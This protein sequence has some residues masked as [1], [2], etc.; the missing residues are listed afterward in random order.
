[1][2][3]NKYPKNAY[4]TTNSYL[5]GQTRA[6]ILLGFLHTLLLGLGIFSLIACCGGLSGIDYFCVLA[7]GLSLLITEAVAWVLL[8]RIHFM[9][10]YLFIGFGISV[11]LAAA[12]GLLAGSY[13]NIKSAL[14]L[15]IFVL[16]MSIV[17]I[18]ARAR[19]KHGEIKAEFLATHDA[20]VPFRMEVWEIPTLLTHPSPWCMLWFAVQYIV[21]LIAKQPLY[22]RTVFYLAL[23]DLFV[24]FAFHYIRQ[25]MVFLQDN[26]TSANL[27][28]R[29]IR[30]VHRIL[31]AVGAVLLVLFVTPAVLYNQEPLSEV[32]LKLSRLP[33]GDDDGNADFVPTGAME[34]NPFMEGLIDTGEVHEPPE[35]LTK[36]TEVLQVVVLA[37]L[38]IGVILAI[39]QAI[40]YAMK[41]FAICDEDEVIFLEDETSDAAETAGSNKQ[42]G[43]GIFS[44]NRQIRRRYKKTIRKA[45]SGIPDHWA[46]PSEL[47]A[48]AGLADSDGMSV[49]H[50]VYEKARYSRNGAT[51]EDA[52]RVMHAET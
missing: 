27:P 26:H 15:A 24:C 42:R 4:D 14:R 30:R 12:G 32:S 36:L 38:V 2:K 3:T 35:W 39:V 23:L 50:E 33:S 47:E 52:E 29:T 43:D 8:R 7:L 17:V 19:A 34:E 48:H 51:R 21:G 5:I 9:L 20:D 22:W 1:M 28:V 45:T 6:C 44:I 31:L 46:T 16:C 13:D 11:L 25:F 40:R 37:V 49:L 10:L 41:N 18:H